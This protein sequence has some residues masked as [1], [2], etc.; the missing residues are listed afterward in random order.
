[1]LTNS[2]S[3]FYAT[4]AQWLLVLVFAAAA[5]IVGDWAGMVLA[6]PA[7]L[8]SITAS[9]FTGLIPPYLSGNAGMALFTGAL[10]LLVMLIAGVLLFGWW[11]IAYAVVAAAIWFVLL[12]I[13]A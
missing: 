4:V 9:V 2:E 1:M 11:G 8:L 10:N 7:V 5:R 13:R 3:R 12:A 6:A